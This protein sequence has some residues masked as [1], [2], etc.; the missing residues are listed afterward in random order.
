[1]HKLSARAARLYPVRL[2]V[3]FGLRVSS[4]ACRPHRASL[5]VRVP[6]VG[7]SL[8]A[9]FARRPRG[10]RLAVATVAVTA[11]G[12]LLSD[13]EFMPMLGTRGPG[14]TPAV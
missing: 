11:S 13:D 8:Q 10:L 14:A 5:P 6:A 1:V 7:L 3:T 12:H 9:S 4:H 2:S